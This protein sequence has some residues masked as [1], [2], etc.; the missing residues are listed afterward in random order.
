MTREEAIARIR[1]AMPTLW[2]ETKDAIQT[3]IPEL[4]ESEDEKNAN[5]LI[6]LLNDEKV[7]LL[8]T[9]EAKQQWLDW[10]ERKKTPSVSFEPAA[11]FDCGSAV[12]YHNDESED[13]RILRAIIKGFENWKSNG[14]E[15][16]NKIK[17]DDILVYLEKCKEILHISETCKENANS[18]TDEDVRIRKG[19]IKLLT[20]ASDAY[21]VEST[22]IKRGSYLAWLEKQK[23]NPKSADS[24]PSDCTADVKCKD[25]WHKVGDSL[26]DNGREVLAKDKLGNILLA[27][28]DGEG[29]DVSVYDDED[30]R[31]HN[32]I[33]KWCE[34]PS[35]K[36]KEQ[37][38]CPEYCVRSHCIGCSIYE[39]QKE[40]KPVSFSCGHE[41]DFVSKPKTSLEI[42]KHYLVWAENSEEDCPYTWKEL[43]D[44]IKDGIAALE[45]KPAECL[46]KRKVYDI[47][48]KLTE[49]S[50]SDLIP[51][52]SEEY[53]KIHEITS[54]VC[55]LLDYPI[56]Q[57]S[58]EWVLPE[59]FEEAVYKVANF[60]SPFDNQEELRKTSHRF[61][62]QL[63]SLAKKELDKPAEWSEEDEQKYQSIRAIL[64]EDTTKKIG[65]R[66][67]GDVLEWY[68]SKGKGRFTQLKQEWS[69]EDEKMLRLCENRIMGTG[70]FVPTRT[71][72]YDMVSWLK[73]LRPQLKS[74]CV[75]DMIT[76]NKEFFKWIYD[77]LVNIYKENPNVDYMISFKKRIEELSFDKPYWKP[78]EEQMEALAMA[79]AFFKTKWTGAKVKEQLALESLYEDLKKLM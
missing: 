61:A 54:D 41:N 51:V 45:Q 9:Y 42:L 30:Y 32:G 77:R 79:V 74:K 71:G 3:I 46:S 26:P 58:A 50:T 57:K 49:L 44:A 7:S 78:S 62:E 37:D 17:V 70:T 16:F 20:V 55:S 59:D 38:K 13:E 33:S 23:E 43:A 29:W 27:R 31:C 25:R 24:I 47:M 8:V 39:K 34:I 6:R 21:L 10:L 40:Q 73:S 64:L 65:K 66:T 18:F 63:L 35:E 15:T 69:E 5:A 67:Y 19:L 56:E 75:G 14:M 48:N 12:V 28:Y 4:A 76:S 72:L 11:G 2:K 36:Q 52:E 60:I 53:V 22:G 1:E 68:E